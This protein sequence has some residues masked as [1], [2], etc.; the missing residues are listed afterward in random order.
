M[1]G[2][3]GITWTD[4]ELIKL[5]GN[6]CKHRGPEQE[7]FY[8][9]DDVSLCCERLR[10]MDLRDIGGRPIHNEVETVWA[11]QNGDIYNFKGSNFNFLDSGLSSPFT[12][13][14]KSYYF[15]DIELIINIYVHSHI[16]KI[17]YDFLR[18]FDNKLMRLEVVSNI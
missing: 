2:I 4:K 17:F 15:N 13:D 16:Y 11:L 6:A 5:M 10:V 1:C 7:G 8:L 14:G 18:N 9:D 12:H 3:C